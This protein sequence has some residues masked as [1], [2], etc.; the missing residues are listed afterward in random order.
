MATS[1]FGQTVS[2]KDYFRPLTPGVIYQSDNLIEN[3]NFDYTT[4]KSS[5]D[6]KKI[7]R[8]Y[9]KAV[10]EEFVKGE[11]LID[12]SIK[13]TFKNTVFLNL[14]NSN[15]NGDYNNVYF[16]IMTTDGVKERY[17]E[18]NDNPNI[19]DEGYELKMP[20]NDGPVTWMN[21]FHGDL[22]SSGMGLYVT[23]YSMK[24]YF[25]KCETAYGVYPDCIVVEKLEE[26]KEM[27]LL[28]KTYYARSIG[29]VMEMYFKRKKSVPTVAQAKIIYGSDWKKEMN[30]DKKNLMI[31]SNEGS[32][33]LEK[34]YTA[35]GPTPTP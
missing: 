21:T 18:N 19:Y 23:Y 17:L 20:L 35:T 13:A 15:P 12:G 33:V 16:F 1:G 6:F 5:D 10:L 3:P 9:R 30:K 22:T 29:K 11:D 28:T 31:W 26:Q 8:E 14:P 7:P 27:D 24:S 2:V 34:I 4:I 32:Q 25:G